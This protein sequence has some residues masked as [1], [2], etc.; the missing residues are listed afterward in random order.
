MAG[1]RPLVCRSAATLIAAFS[2]VGA[3]FGS[4][5]S[6]RA[7]C[8]PPLGADDQFSLIVMSLEAGLVSSSS[9]AL[10]AC[11]ASDASKLWPS[12]YA[13]GAFSVASGF[14]C[15]FFVASSGLAFAA[16]LLVASAAEHA[17]FWSTPAPL[18][19]VAHAHHD[20]RAAGDGH[21]TARPHVRVAELWLLLG[22]IFAGLLGTGVAAGVFTPLT[23]YLKALRAGVSSEDASQPACGSAVFGLVLMTALALG[24]AARQHKLAQCESGETGPGFEMGREYDARKYFLRC[25]PPA[26]LVPPAPSAFSRAALWASNTSLGPSFRY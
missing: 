2:L 16:F 1:A 21:W 26:P 9:F 10:D 8:E 14:A 5:I 12:N 6:Y 23:V 4:W 18:E 3:A 15:L 7:Y 13:F 20:A 25:W 24:V 17:H 22:S 11:G 19:A